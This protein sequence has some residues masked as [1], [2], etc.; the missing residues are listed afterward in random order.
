[1]ILPQLPVNFIREKWYSSVLLCNFWIWHSS[2]QKTKTPMFLWSGLS[3]M[4]LEAVLNRSKI[5]GFWPIETFLCSKIHLGH[6]W[7]ERYILSVW[8]RR[9]P[10][11]KRIVIFAPNTFIRYSS[12][13]RKCPVE[14]VLR[15]ILGTPIKLKNETY[16]IKHKKAAQG[17]T[18]LYFGG[19]R[20]ILSLKILL[21]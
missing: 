11:K 8:E 13:Q 17:K 5:V 1:M 14:Y 7:E 6:R 3:S 12:P 10:R 4:N 18:F 15:Y 21:K 20:Y 9:K 2:L 16:I 19:K